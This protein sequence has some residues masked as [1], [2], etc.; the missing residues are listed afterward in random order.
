MVAYILQHEKMRGKRAEV[1]MNAKIIDPADSVAV[2][3]EPVAKG[4]AVEYEGAAGG[5]LTALEAIPIYHK[6]A[7][8]DMRRGDPVVKYGQ[9]IGFAQC[10]IPAG[11]HVHTHNV[12]SRREDLREVE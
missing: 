1:A 3:V 7:V 10:D 11:A 12:E 8:R 5:A 6:I 9:H 4:G 2:V